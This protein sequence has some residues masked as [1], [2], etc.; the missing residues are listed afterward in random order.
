MP[1]ASTQIR[2]VKHAAIGTYWNAD[3]SV[4]SP[5][6]TL[7]T[8]MRSL[9]LTRYKTATLGG[10]PESGFEQAFSS[11][12]YAY[13][14]DKAP[15]LLDYIV[16]FQLVDRNE[17]NTK[18]MGI[19]GFKVG[20][21]WLYVPVF[22][23]N[24][25]LKGHELL[26]IKKQ[27]MFVPMKENWVNY[28]ISRKPHSLGKG[29]DKNTFE[30]GGLMPNLMRIARP[31]LGTKYGADAPAPVPFDEWSVPFLPLVFAGRM[32]RASALYPESQG[33]HA[34]QFDKVVASPFKA[35]MAGT[36]QRFDL[37]NFLRDNPDLIGAAEKMANSYPL[38]KE[39]LDRFY[40]QDFLDTLRS[41][42]NR[43]I[44]SLV[45]R[46][47]LKTAASFLVPPESSR[48]KTKKG[49][50]FNLQLMD[51]DKPKEKSAEIYV[52]ALD[53]D[54]GVPITVNKPELTEEERAKLLKDTILIKDERDPHSDKASIA[55]NT[56]VRLELLNPS[57][58]GLHQ[59]LEKP[60]K[61]DEMLVISNPHSGRGRENFSL[62]VRKSDPRS[63]LNAHRSNLWAKA[64]GEPERTEFSKWVDGLKGTSDLKKGGTYV[65]IHANGSG[66]CP[67]TIREDYGDGQY[68]VEWR[69]RCRMNMA[70]Q[71]TYSK[72]ERM[73]DYESGYSPWDA[74]VF[75]NQKKGSSLKSMNGELSIPDSYKII[76]V[77]DPPKPKKPKEDDLVG[78]CS[79]CDSSMS[80][81]ASET[82]PIAPGRIEDVQTM[83]YKNAGLKQLKIYD[84][85]ANEIYVTYEGV[86]ERMSKKAALIAL[87]RDH[88]LREEQSRFMLKEAA[89][90]SVHT[91]ACQ[92]LVKH[93][94]GYGSVDLRGGPGAP[95]FPPP[96]MG[97]E[98]MGPNAVPSIYP[99]EE[100]QP[101]DGMS[102]QQADPSVYDPFFMPDQ[103]AMQTAQQASASGQ[104]EVFD[105]SMIGGMLKAVRQETIVDR[106]LGDLMKA[107]DKLGRLIMMFHWHNEEF[108][109]RYGKQ[110]MPELGDALSNNFE[111]LGDLTLFLKKKTV[112]GQ[113]GVDIDSGSGVGHEGEPDIAETAR[114]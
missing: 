91:E 89:A 41:E 81:E 34:L 98:Q 29:S 6:K 62:V 44:D 35:A 65:A 95:S 100:Y 53:V 16:G 66:T 101:V 4:D 10:E 78:M 104:K 76:V 30:L 75:I 99:Q 47:A 97:T 22:F 109:D 28:L 24:G 63:W 86:T 88:G 64:N 8:V 11:L 61:F 32:K 59:V 92:Y 37:R 40:G 7:K 1:L 111:G 27:D 96:E 80:S 57:E 72:D 114:N 12:A 3:D 68:K 55:Y 73:W 90:R 15:R 79:P 84:S 50:R 105:T 77:Q 45:G 56:Q 31:P 103:K 112:K 69:D 38:V 51:D 94:Y 71:H 14:K 26:W 23:L 20:E 106:Y 13:I 18:A 5:I 9:E 113:T 21:Q 85:G 107:V 83:L 17:D 2:F 102:S 49:V 36:A 43:T 33:N 46:A 67:F 82:E 39:G 93:A 110:D 19:F 48:G 52:Y 74:K 70:K 60:G 87:V 42:H 25:D 54:N 58:T 108:Q